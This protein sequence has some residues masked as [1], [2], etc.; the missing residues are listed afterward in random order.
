MG[1]DFFLFKFQ[2]LHPGSLENHLRWQVSGFKTQ[3]LASPGKFLVPG[4]EKMSAF[5]TVDLLRFHG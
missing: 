5:K 2:T 1:R 3:S 4:N